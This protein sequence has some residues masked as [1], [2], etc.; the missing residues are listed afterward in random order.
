MNYY[1]LSLNHLNP[2]C[3]LFWR[4]DNSGYTMI[5]EEAGKYSSEKVNANRLYYDNKKDTV[6]V[7]CHVVDEFA[8]KVVP[9]NGQFNEYIESRNK[10]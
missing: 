10:S 1:I 9:A 4:P 5:L 6:A 7:P 2:E 3:W 8:V